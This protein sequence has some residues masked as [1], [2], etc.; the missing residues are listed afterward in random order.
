MP[1]WEPTVDDVANVVLDQ[2][3]WRRSGHVP[4]VLA[5]PIER[6]LALGLWRHVCDRPPMRY[7][8]ILGPRR[9]GKTTTMYQTVRHLLNAG[10]D[11]KRLW[12]FRLDHPLLLTYSLGDLVRDLVVSEARPGAEAVLFLD[13]LVYAR[14]WELWLK[15]FYDEKWPVHVVAT[16]SATSALARGRWESGAGRW[17]E[18][19]L[20]PYLFAEF[21]DLVG[22]APQVPSGGTLA[23]RLAGLEPSVVADLGELRRRFLLVGGFPELIVADHE[24]AGDEEGRLLRSQQVLRSDAVERAV[25]KDIPQ[26]FGLDNPMALERLLYT[27]AG[28]IGGILS[29]TKIGGALGLAQ[30]TFDRYVSYLERA[31]LVF[32][33]PNYSGTEAAVQRRG[34]KLYFVDGA[35]RNAALQRGLAPL[36]NPVEL[37]M[38][39]EN[40]VA[41]NLHALA[42]RSG[43]RLYFWRDGQHEVDLV[44]DH[45][46]APLA[47][48]IGLSPS[49]GRGGLREFARR[50]PRFE[51]RCWLVAPGAAARQPS[52]SPDGIGTVPLDL[53]LVAVGRQAEQALQQQLGT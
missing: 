47:F 53:L 28:Q 40:L 11:P 35:V 45:P 20:P 7:P 31:F 16:S 5:P 41:G 21:L 22:E 1:I 34:R 50:N 39:T 12:W 17:S 6:P 15:T 4:K 43:V 14:D 8:L 51:G 3:P 38:L 37:G 52:K 48:E 24:A 44:Y 49:H 23:E 26:S 30:P 18:Q 29:P 9:V 36:T 19:Y 2:N 13:E 42:T 32:T 10:V 33:L 25:Y 46:D 27:L